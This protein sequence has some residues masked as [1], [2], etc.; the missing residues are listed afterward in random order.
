MN[1]SRDP[2]RRTHRHRSTDPTEA[3]AAAATLDET[4]RG[5]VSRTGGFWVAA[6]THEGSGRVPACAA[7]KACIASHG[8]DAV[9]IR[10]DLQLGQPTGAPQAH[11]KKSKPGREEGN[12][13]HG[14][15]VWSGFTGVVK[16]SD[17]EIALLT[18]EISSTGQAGQALMTT[19]MLE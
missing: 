11:P 4:A 10:T 6:I 14:Q 2:L 5:Y 15:V 17:D 1:V 12:G 18:N 16:V 13:A 19:D 3:K 9:L 8:C 7:G